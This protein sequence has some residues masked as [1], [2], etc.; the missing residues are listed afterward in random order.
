MFCFLLF[1]FSEPDNNET[2]GASGR[3]SSSKYQEVIF[4]NKRTLKV[5]QELS[6][7]QKSKHTCHTLKEEILACV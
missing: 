5:N 3:Q 7:F 6:Q 4:P 2:Y 1:C